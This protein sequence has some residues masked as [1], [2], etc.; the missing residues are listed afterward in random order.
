MVEQLLADP[1]LV[2]ALDGERAA[3]NLGVWQSERDCYDLLVDRCGAGDATLETGIGVSTALFAALGTVHTCVTPAAVEAERL[4]AYCA[5]RG[6]ATASLR[7][8]VGFSEA[9]LPR[10]QPTPLDVVLIDGGHGFPTPMIDW[11]YAG[12]RL[13]RGGLLV[14]DDVQLPVVASLVG[15]LDADDRWSSVVRTDKWVA[16]ER[17]SEGELYE[18]WWQQPFV[19][20]PRARDVVVRA[21]RRRAEAL[22]ARSPGRRS[23]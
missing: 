13:R 16:F 3:P 9:V 10:L 18:D 7:I 20:H 8:E 12:G 4:R 15:F 14:V 22:L 5:D 17:R 23:G 11:F 6:I 2:H 19:T 21:V 1:P